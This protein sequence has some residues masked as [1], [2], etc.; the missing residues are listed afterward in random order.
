MNGVDRFQ[1]AID[2]LLRVDVEASEAVRGMS[3]AFATRTL[4]NTQEAITALMKKRQEL[5]A[6]VVE[7]GNDPPEIMEWTWSRNGAGAS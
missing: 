7:E 2:A 5:R 1:L 4:A 3:G 6:Y